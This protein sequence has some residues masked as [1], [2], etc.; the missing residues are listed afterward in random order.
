MGNVNDL[1]SNFKN[2]QAWVS[3]F[4]RNK[5]AASLL[6]SLIVLGAIKFDDIWQTFYTPSDLAQARKYIDRYVSL[7]AEDDGSCTEN[8]RKARGEAQRIETFL[9]GI[10]RAHQGDNRYASLDYIYMAMQI[11]APL[12]FSLC[13]PGVAAL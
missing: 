11:K 5:L 3:Y 7:G 13:R 9:Y 1:L 2:T 10:I 6:L 4:L 8:A 12:S